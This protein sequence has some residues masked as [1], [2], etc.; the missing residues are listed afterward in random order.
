MK[1]RADTQRNRE[2]IMAAASEVFGR[3][4][5]QAG[6]ADIANAAGVGRA[7]V[8]RHFP[9][10]AALLT[11]VIDLRLTELEEYASAPADANL[12]ERLLRE[13]GRYMAG[14]PGIITAM[15]EAGAGAELVETA[16]RRFSALHER[17]LEA[18]RRA[19]EIRSDLSVSDLELITAMMAS[20][21]IEP[22]ALGATD[23]AL[24]R[25]ID[26]ILDGIRRPQ[27]A[28]TSIA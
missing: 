21:A 5:P 6:F 15:R 27:P 12:L 20:V 22:P 28:R 24:D 7:T 8:Y 9:D 17:T 16:N 14:L 18:A 26:L 1:A 11:T 10:R 19:G 13:H 3:S 23:E 4:G 2:S 25:M